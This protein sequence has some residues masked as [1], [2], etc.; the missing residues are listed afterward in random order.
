MR[1]G[2]AVEALTASLAAIIARNADLRAF[3][4]VLPE[5]AVVAA[6]ASDARGAVNALR[7]PLDGVVVAIKDNI[8]IAGLV[9]TGGIG[10]YRGAIA[11][12]DA[13]ITTQL[14]AAGA[15]IIGKTNMDEAA[16]GA[17]TD[18]PWFGRCENPR[19]AGYT[20]G[21]SSGGSAAAVA[22]SM[23]TLAIGTDT[24]GSVR[25][26]AAYCGVAG[27]MPSRGA[28]SMDGVMPLAP[29][30]DRL[31]L[32]AASAAELEVIWRGLTQRVRAEQ[33]TPPAPA[34]NRIGLIRK[35]TAIDSAP[36]LAGMMR[37]AAVAV[38]AGGYAAAATIL[39]GLD[40][41]AIRRD[42]FV[43]C[44]IEGAAVHRAA[45]VQNP[46]GFSAPLRKMLAYGAAQSGDRAALIRQ[47]LQTVATF[48]YQALDDVDALL[49]P[50]VAG[51]A[52]L[53]GSAA[54]PDQADFTVLANVGG[55]PAIS[56]PWGVDSAG[57]PMGLQ[58]VGR[59]GEDAQLLAIAARLE[60]VRQVNI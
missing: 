52:F 12:H 29:S 8:D 14:N 48:L 57:M 23:C 11:Q 38:S 40:L 7:G 54:P 26:P 25:I 41:P 28:F 30:L 43:L 59:A 15:V 16:L 22:A 4:Q 24:M 20:P 47:R 32:L 19:R 44:E 50:V 49:V 27:F 18:N 55:L 31:G 33:D 58:V 13:A 51:G 35:L 6:Q 5:S 42:A 21:G 60:A 2:P 3:L 1:S 46:H 10:H 36:G 34:T 37:S 45:L 9:T 39:A 53:H 17:A 56:I